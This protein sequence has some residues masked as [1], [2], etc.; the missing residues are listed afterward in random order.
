MAMVTDRDP[1]DT[2]RRWGFV[3]AIARTGKT[4]E[5]KSLTNR[6]THVPSPYSQR[7][8]VPR[9]TVDRGRRPFWT[10]HTRLGLR[11]AGAV[12]VVLSKRGR[13]RGPKQTKILVTHLAALPPSQVVCISQKRWAMARVNWEP[14]SGR[15]WGEHQVSGDT[16]RREKSV[17]I[18]GLAS[19][20]VRR[21]CHHAM[22]PGKPWSL[23]QLQ[24]ALR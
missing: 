3:L 12:T 23:F 21:V 15:G 17:G 19:W 13:N 10:Y 6:V 7:A 5:E 11:H 14:Q 1:A 4:V 24:Q 22:V 8:R 2:A 9:E 16:N 20:L 18:A